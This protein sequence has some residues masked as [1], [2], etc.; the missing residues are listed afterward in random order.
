MDFLRSKAI[1]RLFFSFSKT[2]SHAVARVELKFMPV[3]PQHPHPHHRSLNYRHV[4]HHTQLLKLGCLEQYLEL[5]V[6]NI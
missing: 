4:Y 1:Y 3:L 2:M 6:T 5:G